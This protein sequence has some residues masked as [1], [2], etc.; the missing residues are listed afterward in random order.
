[1]GT[2]IG[3]VFEELKVSGISSEQAIRMRSV[4]K[5]SVIDVVRWGA[6]R[7]PTSDRKKYL[8]EFAPDLGSAVTMRDELRKL[9]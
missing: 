4:L 1:M 3:I 6:I 8:A 5:T 7:K 2:V 9:Y